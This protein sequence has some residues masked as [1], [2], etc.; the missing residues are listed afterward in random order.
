[1]YSAL[2]DHKTTVGTEMWLNG[3]ALIVHVRNPEFDSKYHLIPCT[4]SLNPAHY[5]YHSFTHTHTHIHTPC[6]SFSL[7]HHWLRL[8]CRFLL[9]LSLSLG[10]TI[11]QPSF[12]F[13][14]HNSKSECH[15]NFGI[16]LYRGK[17]RTVWKVN[18]RN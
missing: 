6:S 9:I 1:M 13:F 7:G 18:L 14:P 11:P 5:L 16:N 12:D 2:S 4:T 10:K 15:S 3:K 17:W 8:S